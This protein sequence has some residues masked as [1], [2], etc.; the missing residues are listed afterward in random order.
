[1]SNKTTSEISELLP[2]SYT[3]V[4]KNSMFRVIRFQG[5]EF[6]RLKAYETLKLSDSQRTI[7]NQLLLSSAST[8]AILMSKFLANLQDKGIKYAPQTF[9]RIV[10][11]LR[12]KKIL[13]EEPLTHLGEPMPQAKIICFTDLEECI[14]H[15]DE[16]ELKRLNA[17]SGA[18]KRSKDIESQ[19]RSLDARNMSREL[20]RMDNKYMARGAIYVEDVI[21]PEVHEISPARPNGLTHSGKTYN[22]HGGGG[23]YQFEASSTTQIPTENA[24]STLIV[25]VNLAVAYNSKMISQG[26]FSKPFEESEFPAHVLDILNVKGIKDSG[27]ARERIREHIF[28]ISETFYYIT[29]LDGVFK[30]E[31]LDHIYQQ[32]RF[33]FFSDITSNADEAPSVVNGRAII[34]PNLYFLTF[35]SIIEKILKEAD[36]FFT[37]PWELMKADTL[38]LFF[39][40][41]LRR[42]QV[43][44]EVFDI[45]MLREHMSY[46]GSL[47]VFKE[48]LESGFVDANLTSK[49]GDDFDFNV[50]G[51]HI[52]NRVAQDGTLQYKIICDEE[53]MITL[54]GATYNKAKGKLNAPTIPNPLKTA[55][56]LKLSI[57]KKSKITDFANKYVTP[58]S[59]RSKLFRAVDF[60]DKTLH[61]VT[62]YDSEEY[63]DMLVEL[64][65]QKTNLSRTEAKEVLD[66][67]RASVNL[68]SYKDLVITPEAFNDFSE[69]LTKATGITYGN[70]YILHL[71]RGYR[72]K[73]FTLWLEKKYVELAVDFWNELP[74]KDD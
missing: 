60:G 11:E 68:L 12:Q 58:E 31:N 3:E 16:E 56:E 17:I 40:M 34:K 70:L 14:K 23:S 61:G 52:T 45:D 9:R 19:N 15:R 24:I 59:Q 65:A 38:V 46:E 26:R 64:V 18:E 71:V 13:M 47:S 32:R 20:R 50:G 7:L 41:H 6:N 69:Y 10:S 21:P 43:S 44:S 62:Q 42:K 39:Y 66:S 49:D 54:T 48:K 33:Q 5:D 25:L 27:Q 28:W 63:K 36:T 73:K 37:I 30:N 35:N 22:S 67:L 8:N 4:R 72:K 29:D 55:S 1:M 53:E 2:D 57:N 74:L 51:Y